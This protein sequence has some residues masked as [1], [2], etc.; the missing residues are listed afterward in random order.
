SHGYA[1]FGMISG[2]FGRAADG[3]RFGRLALSLVEAADVPTYKPRVCYNV[4]NVIN[5]RVRPYRTG[6]PVIEDGIR[7]GAQIGDILW[8][9]YCAISD[10]VLRYVAGEPL[11]EVGRIAERHLVATRK[12]R[13]DDIADLLLSLRQC[14][15]S[16][17][18]LTTSFASLS[19][20]GFDQA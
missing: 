14:A 1:L 17:R 13:F 10:V 11:A 16:L 8:V 9:A 12:V 6:L 15:Q 7:T 19:G 2:L 4:G 3:F 20:D 18:G 5:F